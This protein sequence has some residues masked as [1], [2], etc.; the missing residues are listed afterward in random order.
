MQGRYRDADVEN[1]LGTQQG[2]EKVGR[3]ESSIDIY[4]LP[5]IKEI[6]SR[7]L[8]CNTVGSAW[9]SVMT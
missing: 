1:G 9:C 6:A 5:Y 3:I 4:T 8:L 2:M 7:K